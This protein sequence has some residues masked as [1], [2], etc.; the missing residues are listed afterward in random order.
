MKSELNEDD[1]VL[2]PTGIENKLTKLCVKK[3]HKQEHD[4]KFQKNSKSRSFS[5]S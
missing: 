1:P 2:R 5:V 3:Y 4:Y